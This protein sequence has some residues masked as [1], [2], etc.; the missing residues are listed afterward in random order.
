MKHKGFTVVELIIVIVVIGIL[1]GITVI[2]YG[3]W[4]ER[5]AKTEVMSDLRNIASLMKNELN[6]NNTYPTSIPSSY[7]ASPNVVV[8]MIQSP[9]SAYCINAY[10]KQKS[11]IYYSISSSQAGVVR[12]FLCTGPTSGS[13][14]GGNVPSAPLGIN[15]APDFDQWVLTGTA[16]YN[17]TTKELTLGANGVATSPM[18]RVN[19]ATGSLLDGQFYSSLQSANASIKPN[20]GW[21]SGSSYYGTDGTTL[22]NNSGGYTGN[23]CAKM[24]ALNAWA[25]SANGACIYALGPNV[26]YLKILLYSAANGYASSDLKIRQ[27]SLLLN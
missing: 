18:I 6:F 10:H 25:A 4:R 5:T 1:A 27:P 23:G 14:V 17:T 3:A 21:H 16:A 9:N 26:Y 24:A 7:K 19:G 8:E 22:V 15:I 12:N 20:A 11:T 13:P 2:G